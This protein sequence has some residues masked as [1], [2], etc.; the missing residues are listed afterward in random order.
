MLIPFDESM[1]RCLGAHNAI[2]EQLGVQ[3]LVSSTGANATNNPHFGPGSGFI[4]LDN[5]D[6]IGN[7][8][9]V[10]QCRHNGFGDHNCLPREDAGVFCNTGKYISTAEDRIWE[11]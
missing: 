4:L 2:D 6:C 3:T 9:N 8:V 7:E 1:A 5:V 11:L 10:T